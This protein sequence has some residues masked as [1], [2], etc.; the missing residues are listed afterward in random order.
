MPEHLVVG[1]MVAGRLGNALVPFAGEG[2]DITV[3]KLF[4]H[5]F[6]HGMDIIPD[7]THRTGGKD[8]NG[9]GMKE[10]ISLL[11]RLC[12]LLLATKDDIRILHVGTE[13]VGHVVH[14]IGS[15][16]GQV[17]PGPPSVETTADGAMY[18]VDDVTDRPHD[19][20]LAAGVS[21]AAHGHDAGDGA[22]VGGNFRGLVALGLIDHDLFGALAGHLR[23]ILGQQLRLDMGRIPLH[24]FFLGCCYHFTYSFLILSYYRL[25][26]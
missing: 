10:V 17:A 25:S 21:A 6:G 22:H 26:G 14:A 4:L 18:Q 11:N 12:Q 19:N 20:T 1:D 24:H 23:R 7:Q 2:V 3:T 15:G 9:T 16:I 13:T 5:L 8:G